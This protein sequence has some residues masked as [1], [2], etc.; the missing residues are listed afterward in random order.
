MNSVILAASSRLSLYFD[1][2]YL[3]LYKISSG[4]SLLKEVIGVVSLD[5]DNAP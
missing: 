2:M 5:S 4:N 3:L 1:L